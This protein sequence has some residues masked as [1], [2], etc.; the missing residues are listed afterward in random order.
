[1]K[2]FLGFSLKFLLYFWNVF[3][4]KKKI[5][6][7]FILG[8]AKTTILIWSRKWSD[9]QGERTPELDVQGRHQNI[10]CRGI[11]SSQNTEGKSWSK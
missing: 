11:S 7:V 1:M 3:C 10:Y 9:G 4:L 6:S 8:P 2:N 5:K